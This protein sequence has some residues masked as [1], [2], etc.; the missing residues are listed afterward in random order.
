[1]T[2]WTSTRLALSSRCSAGR[3]TFTTVPSMNAMLEARI[4]AARIHG[5]VVGAHGVGHGAARMTPASEG[6]GGNPLIACQYQRENSGTPPTGGEWTP[7]H[8]IRCA[9]PA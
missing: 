4:V 5:A 7:R 6:G 3:A 9:V 2:H 1:M 8:T